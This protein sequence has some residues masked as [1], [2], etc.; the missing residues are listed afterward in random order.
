MKNIFNFSDFFEFQ[1]DWGKEMAKKYA[2]NFY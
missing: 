1:S 2:P